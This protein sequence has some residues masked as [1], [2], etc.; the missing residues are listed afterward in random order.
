MKNI[1]LFL[2][3]VGLLALAGCAKVDKTELN[4]NPVGAVLNM[5]DGAVVVLDSANKDVPMIFDWEDADYGPQLV[6]TYTLQMDQQGNEFA[7]PATVGTVTHVSNLELVT[8]DFNQMLL[9]Y[10]ANPDI[11]QPLAVEFR[12]KASVNTNVDDIYSA[13]VKQTITPY[14]VVIVYPMLNV[15]GSYQGWDPAD[16]INAI[17]AADLAK[18][19]KFEGYIWFTDDNTEYKF[20]KGSWDENWGDD[21]GDGTLEPGGANI[22]ALVA[23][24]YKLNADL[25]AL[26]HAAVRT[27][28]G[29]IGDATPGG[30]DVSTPMT[31]SVDD[32]TW[33]VTV[34][35]AAG[36]I[37]FRANDAWDINY[38]DNNAN[39]TLQQDGANIPIAAA[40]N[41]T[42]TMDLSHPIYTYTVK[43]N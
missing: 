15:P 16:P 24:Y 4:V 1:G 19:N 25:D 35:L 37:K 9:G 38:G 3:I 20:A 13:V 17:G 28:W 7:D 41:Y 26:T 6:I 32:R 18:P 34:D 5:Q 31:Y 43:A 42:I 30:W 12:V 36:E 14:P 8:S 10:L 22:I 2:T 11:A 21:G 40:G 23:G 27:D 39:G 29:L 33:S